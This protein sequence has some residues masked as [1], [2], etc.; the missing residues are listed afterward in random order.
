[1]KKLF[2]AEA[3]FIGERETICI[4]ADEEPTEEDVSAEF[5]NPIEPIEIQNIREVKEKD[6][7][8]KEK[9]TSLNFNLCKECKAC[10]F[11]FVKHLP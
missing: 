2:L 9:S 11:N 4:Q 1:M 8:G 6:I 3:Y 10:D 7:R 5:I